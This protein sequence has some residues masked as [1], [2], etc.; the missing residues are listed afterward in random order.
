MF[1][2]EA[3][4]L[5]CYDVLR[6]EVFNLGKTFYSDLDSLTVVQLLDSVGILLSPN[7]LVLRKCKKLDI[8]RN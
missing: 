1:I 7:N 2:S 8:N 5:H 3:L 6:W 4:Q